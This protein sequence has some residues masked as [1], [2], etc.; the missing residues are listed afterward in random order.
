MEEVIEIHKIV[1]GAWD[2]FYILYYLDKE[3]TP[4]GQYVLLGWFCMNNFD[5]YDGSQSISFCLIH[6]FNLYFKRATYDMQYRSVLWMA[7]MRLYRQP[8]I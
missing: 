2:H 7:A 1:C 8:E 3:T 5:I 6:I 4:V